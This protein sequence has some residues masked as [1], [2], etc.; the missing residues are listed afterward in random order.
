[1]ILSLYSRITHNDADGNLTPPP[2]T[3]WDFNILYVPHYPIS[4]ILLF[5]H[6][7]TLK[8]IRVVGDSNIFHYSK[9]LIRELCNV[10]LRKILVTFLV[11][12]TVGRVIRKKI[13]CVCACV[14]VKGQRLNLPFVIL[15]V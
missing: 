12:S 3:T 9:F 10:T 11:P 6:G 2:G 4:K 8:R 5:K 14:R 15:T 1:M 13:A 7:L